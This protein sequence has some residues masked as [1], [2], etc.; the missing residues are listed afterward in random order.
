MNAT[1]W[2]DRVDI[3]NEDK[4]IHYRDIS[5]WDDTFLI[6]E[7][8][9]LLFSHI[10]EFP[11]KAA[12]TSKTTTTTPLTRYMTTPLTLSFPSSPSQEVATL[13]SPNSISYMILLFLLS[14]SKKQ[15][16]MLELDWQ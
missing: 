11:S 3:F 6:V 2:L 12:F 8:F 5:E 10:L 16:S 1:E 15:L 14:K 4:S 9:V 7:V 13:L